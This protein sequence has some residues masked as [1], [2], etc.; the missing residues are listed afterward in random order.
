MLRTLIRSCSCFWCRCCCCCCRR[1]RR[2]CCRIHEFPLLLLVLSI[3]FIKIIAKRLPSRSS[4]ASQLI[5]CLFWICF[6]FSTETIW[7]NHLVTSNKQRFF[8]HNHY[9]HLP[10]QSL[11]NHHHHYE[12]YWASTSSIIVT[13][14]SPSL[15]GLW[16]PPQSLSSSYII[17]V[18]EMQKAE[19]MADISVLFF[20][21]VC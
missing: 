8:L 1:R 14:F 7:G 19:D 17:Y 4:M 12:H 21:K 2:C 5:K 20:P 18:A 10:Q 16:E 11:K 3:I 6:F 9:Y 13:T 15:Q